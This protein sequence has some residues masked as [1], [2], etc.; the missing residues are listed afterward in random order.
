MAKKYSVDFLGS[1]PL[2]KRIREEA[3]QGEPTVTAEPGSEIAQKY[4]TMAHKISSTVGIQKR[5]Y[6]NLFPNIEIQNT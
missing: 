1:L 4:R 5:N 3:D 2:D 6:A